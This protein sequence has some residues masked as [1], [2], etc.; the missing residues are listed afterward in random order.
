M[1]ETIRPNPDALLAALRQEEH[2]RSRGRLKVFLG[3]SPG[4]GKTYA[5]LEAARREANRGRDVV[6]GYVESHGRRETDALV[7][8]LE[9]IP[10]HT[11]EHRGITLSELDLDA[12]LARRPHLAVVDE[13]AHT[14]APGLRHP[15]RYQDV[16]ELLD[17]G[18]DVFTTLNVQHVESRAGTVQEITGAAIQETVPDS[19]LDAADIELVDLPPAELIQRLRTGKVY[20]QDCA[21][22]AARSF[23]REGNL[24]ALRELALRLAA[25]RAGQDTRKYRTLQS[26]AQVWKTT[27]RLLVALSPSPSSEA[28][29]RWTRRLADSLQAPWLAVYVDDGRTLSE[30]DQR[31]LQKHLTLARELGA[32]VIATTDQDV[33][34][35]LLRIAQQ[36]N[37]TQIVAGKPGGLRFW[38]RFR[39]GSLL[40]RLIRESGSVDILCVRAWSG[41]GGEVESNSMPMSVSVGPGSHYAWAAGVVAATTGLNFILR[42]WTGYYAVSL[43]YLMAVVGLA[44]FLGRGPVLLAAT[45]SA[46]LWNFLFLPPTY[47]FYITSVQD[48]LMFGVF[49]VVA[50]AMGQ[51]TARLRAQQS[52]ERERERQATALYLLTRELAEVNDLPQLLGV[53]VRQVGSVFQSEV[54]VLLPD[55]DGSR[56]MR[57]GD[58]AG[59]VSYPFGTLSIDGKE[60]SVA[61]WAFRHAKPAGWTTDT[62][63]ASDTLF[64]P[65]ISPGGCL[66]VVGLRS[67]SRREFTL[68]QRTLLESFIRQIALVL[69]RQRL[70][71]AE[72]QARLMAESERLGKTLLNSV[73]HELR[74][75]LA[76]ITTAAS[77]LQGQ[78][79]LSEPVAHL[80]R[81]IQEA[82]TR[83]N[84]LVRNLLD[85]ARLEAGQLRARLDWCDV[86]DICRA[87]LASTE[88]QLRGH[89][90]ELRLP[91]GLPLVKVDF[92]LLEQ[93]LVNLLAN[94]ASHTPVGTQVELSAAVEGSQIVLAVADSGPGIPPWEFPQLF[95]RFYRATGASPGGTGLGLSIVKGFTEACEGRVEVGNRP[96]GGAVFRILLPRR[97]APKVPG[98]GS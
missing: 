15:K 50:L 69:D 60:G 44:L 11:V 21:E 77:G 23:F 10:R 74:T 35:A 31:R 46:L 85:V 59:L 13:L 27:P 57:N 53:V 88:A 9:T 48:A 34:G 65:L 6:V 16:L 76:A 43:V 5:M 39:G 72:Q 58:S 68:A 54:V 7:E 81:E 40:G 24:M 80:G 61:A 67:L 19:V 20:T 97:E 37:V 12:L 70:R 41:N 42:H 1:A 28:M 3:M 93:V 51:L 18:M 62:L 17:A 63:P 95:D 75:P 82:A 55:L 89:R 87:A 90:V 47:T 94:A 92:V 29:A 49:F 96:A 83:L 66:G 30:E 78:P 36:H 73:S 32:E 33:V 25:E 22:A 64:L 98:E 2:T 4:V 8:G 91:T 52:A 56:E 26:I 14:N 38:D 86:G 79:G 71:D 45:L 84:R